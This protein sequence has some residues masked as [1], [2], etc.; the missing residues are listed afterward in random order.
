MFCKTVL[1]EV[2]FP[3]GVM[4][5]VEDVFSKKKQILPFAGKKAILLP[6]KCALPSNGK[7]LEI[8]PTVLGERCRFSSQ[9]SFAFPRNSRISLIFDTES[10]SIYRS[11]SVP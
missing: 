4:V 3:I 1:S 7:H 6:S 8:I 10:C 2:I 9:F 11:I 5:F